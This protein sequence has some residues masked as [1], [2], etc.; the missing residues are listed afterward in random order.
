MEPIMNNTPDWHDSIPGMLS[1][2]TLAGLLT[3]CAWWL[4]TI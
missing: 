3:S 1:A 4:A 2:M